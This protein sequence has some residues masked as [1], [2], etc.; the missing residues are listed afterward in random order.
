MNNNVINITK[1]NEYTTEMAKSAYDKLGFVDKIFEPISV[2]VDFGCADGAVTRLMRTF[3]NPD[4]TRILGYDLPEIIPV[5]NEEDV[6]N[7]IYFLNALESMKFLISTWR[8][9]RKKNGKVLLVMNSVLH[10]IYN[11]MSPAEINDLYKELFDVVDPDYIWVRDMFIQDNDFDLS[12]T[13]R[14]DAV[15]ICLEKISCSTTNLNK[16]T[17]FLRCNNIHVDENHPV[18]AYDMLH[19]LM[20]YT[21]K[22]WDKEKNENYMILTHQCNA[23]YGSFCQTLRYYGF[24][25]SYCNDYVLPYLEYKIRNEMGVRI[26]EN[27]GLY[28][29]RQVLFKKEG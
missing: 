10:E 16:Y 28:T 3:Y 25:Q 13:K 19:F 11:Y 1:Q 27:F 21:Y 12:Y 6:N 14:R 7:N 20:K 5:Y 8:D 29:H 2:I 9:E 24:H 18:S 26:S 4:E 22:N 17:E 15:D 23:A